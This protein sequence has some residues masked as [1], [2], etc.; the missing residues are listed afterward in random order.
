MKMNQKPAP[1]FNHPSEFSSRNVATG[2]AC[3][4]FSTQAGSLLEANVFFYH[5]S[6]PYMFSPSIII[7]NP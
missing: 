3:C 5:D 2:T 7:H 6:L 4:V 1:S